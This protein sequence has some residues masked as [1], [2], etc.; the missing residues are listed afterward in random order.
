MSSFFHQISMNNLI[1]DQ[2]KRE[3]FCTK[4]DDYGMSLQFFKIDEIL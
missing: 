1:F 4:F 3:K 2:I